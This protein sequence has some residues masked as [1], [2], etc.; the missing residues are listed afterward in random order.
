MN[1]YC[2]RTS[3]FLPGFPVEIFPSSDPGSAAESW[4]FV[5]EDQTC[6]EQL[7]QGLEVVDT[8]VD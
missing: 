2:C 8:D 3:W 1:I 5:S 4:R 7:R 6:L